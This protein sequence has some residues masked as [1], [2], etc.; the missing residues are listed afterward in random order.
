MTTRSINDNGCF[1]QEMGSIM[2]R[3]FNRGFF[4]ERRTKGPYQCVRTK[5]SE[6]A[7]VVF[8][9]MQE[10]LKITTSNLQPISTIL[11]FKNDGSSHNKKL[12][13]LAKDIW[14][15]QQFKNDDCDYCSIST[16][17]FETWI[18]LVVKECPCQQLLETLYKES[19]RRKVS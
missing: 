17:L 14:H 19:V 5:S 2:P 8:L 12:L 6:I 10:N 7:T 4:I 9:K 16:E 11:P 3:C 1:N 13:D 18:R 15:Y